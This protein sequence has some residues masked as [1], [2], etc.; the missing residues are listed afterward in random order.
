MPRL[1]SKH[2]AVPPPPVSADRPSAPGA[3]GRA[4]APDGTHNGVRVRGLSRGFDGRAVLENL[5]L[6][7][8]PGEFV[9]LLG[10]SGS[11]KSTLL[12][13]VGGLDG[14]PDG[15]IAVPERVATVFQEHRLLPWERVWKNVTLGLGGG[16]LRER[17]VAALGEV[18]LADRADA[19]PGTLSGGEAQ[20]VA[21]GRAL[22]RT[23]QLLLL[24]EPFAALDALT[25]LK[26]QQLVERLWEQHRPSVL[27]VTHDVEE[28]LLLADRAVLL[29]D[30][31][32]SQ[33]FVV[34][35][36]RPRPLDH[37]RFVELRRQLLLGLGV[38]PDAG[39][40]TAQNTDSGK[41]SS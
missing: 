2:A 30:R 37:P 28:A 5:D 29:G 15:R 12:R 31:T 41:A 24:D 1:L 13:A 27:L 11:G 9:A 26:A 33:E 18:G 21:L 17:A 20:R 14:D 35:I 34:D 38:D 3:P 32:L 6:D 7:I 19:W 4:P 40:A 39:T 23:P 8:A 25:R 36:P 16:L 10:P 22:V